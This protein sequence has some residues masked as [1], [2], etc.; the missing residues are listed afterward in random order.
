MSKNERDQI[1]AVR[2]KK[3][4]EFTKKKPTFTPDNMAKKCHACKVLCEWVISVENYHKAYELV[5]DKLDKIEK[6]REMLRVL[7]DEEQWV[8]VEFVSETLI[9]RAKYVLRHKI[10]LQQFLVDFKIIFINTNKILVE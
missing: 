5:K 6:D 4:A 9:E 10:S 8:N 7:S 3:V 1:P 2:M